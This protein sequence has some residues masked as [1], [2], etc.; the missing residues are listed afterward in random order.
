MRSCATLNTPPKVS[1]LFDRGAFEKK[2]EKEYLHHCDIR[3]RWK[4]PLSPLAKILPS[5]TTIVNQNP[6]QNPEEKVTLRP[7]RAIPSFLPLRDL[8]LTKQ[9]LSQCKVP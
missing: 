8:H 5:T 7:R 1:N 3:H 6:N 4:A 9:F 2:G